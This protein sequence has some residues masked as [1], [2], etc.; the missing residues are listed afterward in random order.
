M[1][2][3]VKQLAKILNVSEKSVYRDVKNGRI[4]HFRIRNRIR[5]DDRQLNTYLEN[6]KKRESSTYVP[7][8][9]N[10]SAKLKHLNL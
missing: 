5:V 1:L 3:S 2:Y 8:P 9:R 7:P 4:E 10:R 6:Q